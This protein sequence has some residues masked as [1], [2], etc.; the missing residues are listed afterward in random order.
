MTVNFR[1][2]AQPQP[3][4]EVFDRILR[5]AAFCLL[6]CMFA[7]ALHDVS[8][9]WDVWYYHL[10]FAARLWQLVPRSDFIFHVE[11]EARYTGFPLLGEWLQGLL[12]RLTG[13]PTA[14][15]LV[16]LGSVPA[17]AALLRIRFAVPLH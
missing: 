13:L 14:A 12:W 3:L 5:F 1:F 7:A 2:T 11:N 9:A 15:T 16:A 6:L 8:R 17:V 10:P 4:E